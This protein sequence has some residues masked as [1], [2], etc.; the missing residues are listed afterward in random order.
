MWNDICTFLAFFL[1]S[2]NIGPHQQFYTRVLNGHAYLS[3]PKTL[4]SIPLASKAGISPWKHKMS[5]SKHFCFTKL[6]KAP[7]TITISYMHRMYVKHKLIPYLEVKISPRSILKMFQYLKKIY[8]PQPL[9]Q[10]P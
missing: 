2:I 5:N 1:G 7:Y 4:D 3:S 9:N 6:F 8:K 10:E